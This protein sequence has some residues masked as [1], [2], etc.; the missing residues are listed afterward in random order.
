MGQQWPRA[1]VL[2]QQWPGA[3][4]MAQ[5]W[6]RVWVVAQGQQ[7]SITGRRAT[8]GQAAGERCVWPRAPAVS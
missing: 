4:M 2:T 8:R 1:W 6:P 3:W 7:E 5:Q